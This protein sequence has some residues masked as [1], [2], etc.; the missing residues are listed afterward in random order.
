MGAIC[1]KLINRNQSYGGLDLESLLV[2]GLESDST[3]AI[4]LIR[5]IS[6]Q[7]TQLQSDEANDRANGWWE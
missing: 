6:T 1:T 4:D 5:E 7:V 2:D 3:A